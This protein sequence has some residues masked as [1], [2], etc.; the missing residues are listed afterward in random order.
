MGAAARLERNKMELEV[1]KGNSKWDN[2]Y[3]YINTK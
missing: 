2:K 3:L 1:E